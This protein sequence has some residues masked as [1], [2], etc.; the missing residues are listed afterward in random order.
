MALPPVRA[1]LSEDSA[2]GVRELVTSVELLNFSE[3]IYAGNIPIIPLKV[4]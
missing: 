3:V 1:K 4:K 2:L